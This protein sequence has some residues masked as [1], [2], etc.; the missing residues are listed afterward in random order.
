MTEYIGEFWLI[1]RCLRANS[2]DF[3]SDCHFRGVFHGNTVKL[4][5]LYSTKEILKKD[6]TYLIKANFVMIEK[7]IIHADLDYLKE[8]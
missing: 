1:S 2:K 7:G 3:S 5:K 8:L 6:F 4:I